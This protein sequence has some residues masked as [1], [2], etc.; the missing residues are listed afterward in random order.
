MDLHVL[1]NLIFK[2][3]IL[4]YPLLISA[5]LMFYVDLSD[6]NLLWLRLR[7]WSPAT[8]LCKF[9]K[10]KEDGLLILNGREVGL[11][12]YLGH[13]IDSHSFLRQKS[14][15]K[16]NKDRLLCLY[17]QIFLLKKI[18]YSFSNVPEQKRFLFT[19]T[20]NTPPFPRFGYI[21]GTGSYC[22]CMYIVCACINMR[23]QYTYKNSQCPWG[24]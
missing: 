5:W 16:T 6:Y 13:R 18:C 17:C 1:Q 20:D 2:I 7:T 24:M 19:K 15:I 21:T 4:S 8:K 23:I 14:Y 22:K 10:N 3:L 9:K 11:A 12:N